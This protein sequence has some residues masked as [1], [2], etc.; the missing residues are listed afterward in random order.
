MQRFNATAIFQ[1]VVCLHLP[2]I[3]IQF[4]SISGMFSL[5]EFYLIRQ[6]LQG[7]IKTFSTFE[8]G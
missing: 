3:N 1:T 7:K 6:D 8:R 2:K 4:F 5:F